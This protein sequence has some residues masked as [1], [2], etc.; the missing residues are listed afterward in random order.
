M[1]HLLDR[2][3]WDAE[4]VHTP[5]TVLVEIAATRWTIETN[6]ETA[7]G[8]VGSDQYEVRSWHGWHRHM[9][10][11]LLAQA[12]LAVLRSVSGEQ[13]AKRGIATPRNSLRIFR[14]S[15]GLSCR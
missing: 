4:P 1:Q 9:T 11:C 3:V 14:Q 6:F 10:L 5:L 2:A 8:E 13:Q 7:K 12:F 15:R